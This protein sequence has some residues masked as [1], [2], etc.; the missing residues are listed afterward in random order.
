MDLQKA[1]DSLNHDLL[2]ARLKACVLD[3]NAVSLMRRYQ[4]N[5]LQYF[6]INNY[7]R[8]W[9]KIPAGVPQGSIL[10]PLFLSMTSY[11]FKSVTYFTILSKWFYNKYMVQINA[12]LCYQELTIHCKPTWYVV[13]KL[14]TQNRKKCQVL[15]VTLDNKLNFATHLLTTKNFNKK[16][17]ALTRVQKYMSNGHKTAYVFLLY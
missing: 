3:N 2:L 11:F 1:L 10:G 7:F 14:L 17:N 15:G 13:M 5:R 4:T 9:G 8:E 12:H 16:F 6:K